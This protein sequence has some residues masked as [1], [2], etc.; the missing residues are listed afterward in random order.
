MIEN[1][2]LLGLPDL[3]SIARRFKIVYDKKKRK[4][5]I[6]D[7]VRVGAQKNVFGK[8]IELAYFKSKVFIIFVYLVFSVQ[9][10]TG[11]LYRISTEIWNLFYSIFTLYSPIFMDSSNL[12][13]NPHTALMSDLM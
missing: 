1:L 6:D 9:K 2:N 7:L 3:I 12:I 11:N 4:I 10:I 8:N 13:E 5:L